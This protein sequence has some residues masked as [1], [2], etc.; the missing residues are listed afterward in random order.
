MC[1]ISSYNMQAYVL[2]LISLFVPCREEIT[3]H[4]A[5]LVNTVQTYKKTF[6]YSLLIFLHFRDN[7]WLFDLVES[8]IFLHNFKLK[9]FQVFLVTGCR[10]PLLRNLYYRPQLRTQFKR[11]Q[12]GPGTRLIAFY[13]VYREND[14]T[15]DYMTFIVSVLVPMCQKYIFLSPRILFRNAPSI[16]KILLHD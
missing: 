15:C 12:T 16:L 4:F 3:N 7:V 8:I 13:S 14:H 6:C 1:P 11:L 9:S 2:L 5:P 10:H